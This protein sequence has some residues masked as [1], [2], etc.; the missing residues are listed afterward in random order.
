MD[1]G[2]HDRFQSPRFRSDSLMF[3]SNLAETSLPSNSKNNSTTTTNNNEISRCDTTDDFFVDIMNFTSF[4]PG[5]ELLSSGPQSSDSMTD[6]ALPNAHFSDLDIGDHLLGELTSGSMSNRG[7][8]DPVTRLV[9]IPPTPPP[10]PD[11]MAVLS[12]DTTTKH[13]VIPPFSWVRKWT[14]EQPDHRAWK[15]AAEVE[16]TST[17]CK[18]V[19]DE[20]VRLY[21]QF[22]HPSLPILSELNFF[23]TVNSTNNNGEKPRPT[24]SLAMLNAIMWAASGVRPIP[25]QF[26]GSSSALTDWM[27]VCHD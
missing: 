23:R 1:H 12:A 20:L 4:L 2:S 15:T 14:V 22:F 21:F 5:P 13:T 17:P 25:S 24:T 26:C 16:A 19:V 27:T 9:S 11:S 6:D 7:T 18:A 10:N 8:L 3:K